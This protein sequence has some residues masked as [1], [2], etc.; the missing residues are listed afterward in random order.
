MALTYTCEQHVVDQVLDVLKERGMVAR[1]ARFNWDAPG[2]LRREVAYRDYDFLLLLGR[3]AEAEIVRSSLNWLAGQ[4]L[5]AREAS[6][7]AHA[8][9]ALRT[10]VRA[11]FD[12]PGTSITPVMERLLYALSAV[13]RPRRAIGLGTYCGYAL[14]W[15]AGASCGPGRVYAADRVIGIDIDAEATERA[16][17]NL[18][19]LD[20]TAHFELLAEDGLRAVERLE[21]PFDYVYLDAESRDQGKGIN[22]DLLA[23]LY[24]KVEE[25]GWVL[26]HDTTVPP[27]AR[28]FEAYLAFVRDRANFRESISF[29]VDPFG[30]ELSIK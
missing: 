14:V 4:N 24:D 13:R 12:I 2:N 11:T 22:L 3:V 6:Y 10:E 21:G 26:A 9:E 30:L 17:A 18:F 5:V 29:D 7:D 1:D 28:Q 23:R 19:K 20:H 27:F 8:F 25:G 16:R 15:V